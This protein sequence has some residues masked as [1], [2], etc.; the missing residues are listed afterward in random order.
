MDRYIKFAC[1]VILS[2]SP[3]IALSQDNANTGPW[4]NSPK[5]EVSDDTSLKIIDLHIKARGGQDALLAVKGIRM[6]GLLV[7]GVKDYKIE[8]LYRRP[9]VLML[10]STRTHMGDDY[11]KIS[12]TDGTDTWTQSLFPKKQKPVLLSNSDKEALEIDARLPHLFLDAVSSENIYAYKGETK[13]SGKKVYVIRIWLNNGSQIEALFDS[14]S[15]HII[16]YRQ[17][18]KIGPRTVLVDR[19][20]IGLKRVNDTWW[21]EGYDFRLGGKSFRKISYKKVFFTDLPPMS[22]FKKPPTQEKWLRG[23]P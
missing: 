9:N 19:V 13:F 8:A 10:K 12:V 4:G 17:T 23:S 15:F 20:P 21:E 16:N 2:L 18:Y 3:V 6:D 1:F 11:I 5:P 7:E 22:M 14:Q